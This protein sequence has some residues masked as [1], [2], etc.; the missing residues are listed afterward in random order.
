MTQCRIDLPI[1]KKLSLSAYIKGLEEKYRLYALRAKTRKQLLELPDYLL[2]DI[3]LDRHIA[4]QE[5]R[6]AFWK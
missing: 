5:A 4:N 6:K 3:G 1:Q 2:K